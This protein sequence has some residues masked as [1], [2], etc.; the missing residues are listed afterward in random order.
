[1]FVKRAR[2]RA[3]KR[4]GERGREELRGRTFLVKR[5]S[6]R[7]VLQPPPTYFLTK[8]LFI[9]FCGSVNQ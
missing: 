4:E 8:Q 7:G 5:D 1:M 2:A 6:L 3:R 9:T